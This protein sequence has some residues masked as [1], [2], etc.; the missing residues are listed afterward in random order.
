MDKKLKLKLIKKDCS[1]GSFVFDIF[2]N[3]DS[4]LIELRV[5]E[6]NG[7]KSPLKSLY[8]LSEIIKYKDNDGICS[9][10]YKILIEEGQGQLMLFGG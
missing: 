2:Y 1:H 5:K 3:Q 7:V 9:Y 8:K 6:K 10:I 4:E